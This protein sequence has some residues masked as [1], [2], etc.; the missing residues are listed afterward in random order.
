MEKKGGALFSPESVNL[1]LAA[2][3]RCLAAF[4]F[5]AASRVTKGTAGVRVLG[6]EKRKISREKKKKIKE[7]PSLRSRAHRTPLR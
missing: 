6:C 2:R 4:V 3:A 1:A 7:K 5:V